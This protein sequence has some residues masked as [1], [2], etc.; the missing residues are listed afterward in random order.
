MKGDVKVVVNGCSGHIV[1]SKSSLIKQLF[2]LIRIEAD[3]DM[4]RDIFEI[5]R[6]WEK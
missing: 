3:T 4:I 6:F 1:I 2:S 5:E